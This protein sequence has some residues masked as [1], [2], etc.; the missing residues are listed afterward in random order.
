MKAMILERQG[1]VWFREINLPLDIGPNDVGI[2]IHTVGICGSDVQFYTHGSIGGLR[3]N[4]PMVFGH[5]ASGT[6]VEVESEVPDIPSRASKLGPYNV[7]PSVVFWATP[8]VHGVLTT[9]LHPAAFAYNLPQSV[10]FAEGAM[11]KPFAIGHQSAA[12]ARIMPGDVAAAIRSGPIGIMT[13][14]AALAQGCSRVSD[15]S[16]E[17]LAIAGHYQGICPV[18]AAEASG[19]QNA[20]DVIFDIAR[21]GGAVVLVGLPVLP[22]TFNSHA[23]ILDR[24][25]DRDCD[26]VCQ[27]FR[28]RAFS[29]LKRQSRSEGPDMRYLRL[30][31]RCSS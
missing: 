21:P 9:I 30:R 2:A 25:A 6:I 20:F 17:K 7:D 19:S 29:N 13:A 1:E 15:F 26:A 28:P 31:R 18:N 23:A 24:S 12:R 10:S 8:S 22:A 4:Q 11:V 16:S 14:M 27:C 3:L 5:E